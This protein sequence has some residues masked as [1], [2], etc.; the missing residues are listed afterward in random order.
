MPA[1]SSKGTRIEPNDPLDV[2]VATELGAPVLARIAAAAAA[3]TAGEPGDDAGTPAIGDGILEPAWDAC[4]PCEPGDTAPSSTWRIARPGL[5]CCT[6]FGSAFMPRICATA[7][8]RP[9]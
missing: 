1:R 3:W 9:A 8:P 2:S 5:S 6:R 7:A 4:E